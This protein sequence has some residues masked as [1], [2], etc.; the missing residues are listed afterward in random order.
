MADE[1][2]ADTMPPSFEPPKRSSL[3]ASDKLSA[4]PRRAIRRWLRKGFSIVVVTVASGLLFSISS[5]VNR[6][7]RARADV[8]LVTLVQQRQNEVD[9]LSR[10]TAQLKNQVDSYASST[11][12]EV[13]KT[14]PA[15]STR[16]VSGPGVVITLTDAPTDVIPEGASPNDL[17]IHQ[18]DI[19][20]VMNAL[21]DGGAEAMTVQG[22]RVTSRTVI[23]CIGNVILVDGTSFSPPY[24]IEAIGDPQTLEETV[25]ANP[26]I[27]N[28]RT[29]VT[30]YGLG[31]RMELKDSLNLPP[32]Q[33][34]MT[35]QYAQVVNNDG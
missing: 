14:V 3:H 9:D 7:S 29:Y 20:D 33:Q 5:Q 2:S 31:W 22:V 26:R 13:L 28:Y 18:Q 21:W 6:D 30:L 1:Y 27:V 10:Q 16:P 34:D 35:F 15:L 8:D 24:V 11:P 23:R 32:A 25:A 19:E 17:V 12:I 4:K